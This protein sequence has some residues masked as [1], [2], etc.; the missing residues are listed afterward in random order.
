MNKAEIQKRIVEVDKTIDGIISKA[1]MLT[2]DQIHELDMA[3][4]EMER[5]Q[6]QLRSLEDDGSK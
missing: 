4:A 6:F 3:Y 2:R 1:I 5:L